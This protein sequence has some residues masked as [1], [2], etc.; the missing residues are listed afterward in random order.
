MKI[1]MA[2]IKDLQGYRMGRPTWGLIDGARIDA[3]CCAEAEC[4]NCGHKGMDYYPF[5]R[6]NPQSYRAFAVC[7][8]CRDT[9]EI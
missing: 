5:V 8:E 4:Q 2:F 7:P 3:Q 9:Y 1:D 6:D